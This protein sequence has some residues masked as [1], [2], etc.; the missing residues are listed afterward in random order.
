MV[1]RCQ[2]LHRIGSGHDNNAKGKLSICTIRFSILKT[3]QDR[4]MLMGKGLIS[5]FMMETT[6]I[7]SGDD[8]GFVSSV[9]NPGDY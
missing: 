8:L 4:L 2:L 9:C 3:Q 1:I 6:L 5:K 7:K